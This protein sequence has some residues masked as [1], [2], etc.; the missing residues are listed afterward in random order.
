MIEETPLLARRS[1]L[2]KKLPRVHQGDIKKDDRIT[3]ERELVQDPRGIGFILN[4]KKILSRRHP[5]DRKF[6]VLIA[7]R[8]E[9]IF[10]DDHE[11]SCDRRAIDGIIDASAH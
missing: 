5:W 6:S 3:L 10:P 9:L 4:A 11:S 1:A 8:A 7:Q 2:V